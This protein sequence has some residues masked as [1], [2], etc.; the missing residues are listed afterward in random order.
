LTRQ[1]S[2]NARTMPEVVEFRASADP[3]DVIHR[4][5][6]V[7]SG[8]GLV[9]IP[10]DTVYAVAAFG[11]NEDAVAS[12]L[13][14][15]G[16]DPLNRPVLA[17]KSCEEVR[18]YVTNISRLGRKLSQRCW[19]GPVTLG[20]EITE[21]ETGLT[22]SLP[23]TARQALFDANSMRFRVSANP[24]ATSILELLPAPLV[25]SAEPDDD[26]ETAGSA[27]EIDA[28]K[29]GDALKMIIDDGPCRYRKPSTIIDVAA[30][31][32][33]LVRDGVV[34]E[35]TIS[36]LATEIYLFVCTGNTCRSPMAEALFRKLLAER[37]QCSEDE[38]VNQGY[39]SLSAGI[40]AGY[41]A[42]ASP[43]SVE[44]LGQMGIDL[45]A[46]ASQPLTA[47]LLGQVDHVYTMTKS[48]LSAIASSGRNVENQ[49]FTLAADGSDISDPIGGGLAEYQRC[50]DEIERHMTELV[51][52]I[53]LR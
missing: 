33:S 20:F 16:P 29:L 11:L 23:K 5:V 53:E 48:H 27:A 1:D 22:A 37:L 34:S 32:W 49:S 10:T 35:K 13:D 46:H 15:A 8:G 41:G 31:Q 39:L 14:L 25:L 43:E 12:L 18:D 24:I 44:I 40:A 45:S 17:V 28:E 6:E 51:S 30:E 21:N 36:R 4:A 3:R 7:L 50:K 2:K 52:S 42:P 38:L 26:A 47:Q 19:P 9:A